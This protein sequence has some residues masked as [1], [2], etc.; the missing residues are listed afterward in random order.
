MTLKGYTRIANGVPN[1]LLGDVEYNVKELLSIYNQ[2]CEAQVDLFVTPELSVTG[3]SM[4]DMFH[5]RTL[6]DA[7]LKGLTEI[8]HFTRNCRPIIIVGLPIL[9]DDSIYNCAA[10][11]HNGAILGII[12]KSYMPTYNEFYE[13]RWFA[14]A[15][16]LLTTTIKIDNKEIPI[17][18]DLLFNGINEPKLR[19]GVEICEDLWA[20]I[21]PSTH[22]SLQGALI[23]ANLSAS[24]ELIAKSDYRKEL[25]KNQ[26]AR[27]MSA[28]VYASSGSCESS[29]DITYGGHCLIADNG[30]IISENDRFSLT[31]SFQFADIDLE[32][33][34]YDRY[35]SNTY[36]ECK[37]EETSFL[38]R[39]IDF[40][41][42][43]VD[44]LTT[45]HIDPHPFV[46]SN[47][48]QRKQRCEEIFHIQT[49]A[50]AKRITHIGEPKAI[51]GISGGL[52]STL[53]LLVA[54]KTFDL[55]NRNRTD[56]IGVTM[57]GFGTTD[58]TYKNAI[59]LMKA[60]HITIKEIPITKSVI[61]HFEDIDHDISLHDITYENS[62][63][64]ERTQILMDLSNKHGGIVIGTGD[65]SE[66]ALGWATYNGDHMS[67]YGVNV[68]I[69]KTLVRYLVE[70]VALKEE[71][72][73]AKLILCDILETPVSPELLPPSKDGTIS[74]KTEEVVGPYE[75][76]DFFLYYMLRYGFTPDKIFNL[77]SIA[78][79]DSYSFQEIKSWMTVFYKRFF[80]Q[81]FKRSALPDGPKVGSICLSPRGDLRMPSDLKSTTWLKYIENIGE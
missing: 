21:P 81:Q 44:R 39:R 42:P 22:V 12:P 58:R 37:L 52:D 29:T 62:Q 14:K 54:V 30:S 16:S 2:A 13:T 7:A 38:C 40:E 53:A 15:N 24:N 64:R 71:S 59:E 66:L 18:T 43:T 77:A 20:P 65:L 55:L 9:I 19:F 57:P 51:I 41:Q 1:M 33:L 79:K 3:Y 25:V 28:Y 10:V 34:E 27:M 46:P 32:K 5:Q 26:S 8:A 72:R 73:T 17:G 47:L 68:S 6:L 36:R 49:T 45:R 75:L 48:N 35:H 56:I 78:F 61:Q 60:L 4:A 23:I 50:L 11:V 67:M 31:S 63:A 80:S 69:P 76:H 70:W 74:Q